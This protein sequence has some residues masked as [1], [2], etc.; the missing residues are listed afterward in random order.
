MVMAGKAEVNQTTSGGPGC[1]GE[2]CAHAFP[3]IVTWK[4]AAREAAV[5]QA[6]EA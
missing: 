4:A 3:H 1:T 2:T 6:V 5:Q